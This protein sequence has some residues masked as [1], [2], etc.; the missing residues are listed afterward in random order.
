MEC[1]EIV[2]W[3]R[4]KDEKG[5]FAKFGIV[6]FK[7]VECVLRCIRLLHNYQIGESK[8]EIKSSQSTE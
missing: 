1:G 7:S 6:E 8:L 3:K 4:S 2:K 5:N